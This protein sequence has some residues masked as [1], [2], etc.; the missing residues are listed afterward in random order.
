MPMIC[1]AG[2]QDQTALQNPFFNSCFI[3]S[4]FCG[5]PKNQKEKRGKKNKKNKKKKKKE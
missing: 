2:S 4:C 3:I 5:K 1:N